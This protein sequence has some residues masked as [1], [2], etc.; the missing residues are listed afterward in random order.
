MSMVQQVNTSMV[1]S[2]YHHL[3]PINTSWF[4][5][6]TGIPLR[7]GERIVVSGDYDGQYPHTRVMA[8]DHVYM[9][10]GGRVPARCA[11]FPS[12]LRNENL[13]VPGRTAPPRVVVPLTGIGPDGRARTIARPPGATVQL[14]GSTTIRV[15]GF[16]FSQSNLSVPEGATLT[17]SFGDRRIKHDVTLANGP[18]GFAAPYSPAT[19]AS[20]PLGS[21]T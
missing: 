12:D 3:G 16:R 11:P 5:T 4:T 7:K 10:F 17:W 15:G 8:I 6:P 9:A 20:G 21:R 1:W 13:D 14:G 2:R 18:D 19:W